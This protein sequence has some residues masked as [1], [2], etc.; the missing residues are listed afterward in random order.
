MTMVV[1][2]DPM[3][4]DPHV[5]ATATAT[6]QPGSSS[7]HKRLAMAWRITKVAGPALV[8]VAALAIS[9]LTYL[10]QHAVNTAAAAASEEAYATK[11]TYWLKDS[12]PNYQ[13]IIQNSSTAPISNVTVTF[14][15]DFLEA[16]GYPGGLLAL[17][18]HIMLLQ[19]EPT[20]VVRIGTIPPCRIATTD[21]VTQAQLKGGQRLLGFKDLTSKEKSWIKT[22]ITIGTYIEGVDFT[23]AN[24][25][26]WQR[27][28]QDILTNVSMPRADIGAFS[29]TPQDLSITPANG[30]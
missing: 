11:V 28:N 3:T 26:S 29:Y 13:I 8:S 18:P 30:C 15:L 10:D 1:Y 14:S 22:H 19:M 4:Q 21:A 16:H 9:L 17:A 5:T 6:S 27:N 2:T 20:A 25:V 7:Q 24:G 23:D 12:F